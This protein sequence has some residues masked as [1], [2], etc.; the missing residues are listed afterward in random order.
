M[1]PEAVECKYSKALGPLE[2][3][4][5]DSFQ[6]MVRLLLVEVRMLWGVEGWLSVL[7]QRVAP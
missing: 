3:R 6:T 1:L 7:L 2:H 5:T 4:M